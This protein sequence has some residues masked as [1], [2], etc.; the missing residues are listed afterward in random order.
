MVSVSAQPIAAD[1][2]APTVRESGGVLPDGTEYR[3][4]VPE[5]WNGT[6]IN[7]LDFVNN[8][9]NSLQELLLDRGYA[10]SGTKR[11][12]LRE[13]QYDPSQEIDNQV[14]V[15]DI[16][17][18]EYGEPD[19]ALQFGCSGGGAVAMGIGEAYPDKVDGVIAAGYQTGVVIGNMWLDLL[20]ILKGLLAPDSDLP[21]VGI[22]T[23]EE[24]PVLA[25]WREVLDSAQETKE[26][27]ARIALAVALAQWPT[28]GALGNPIPDK[29]DFND[30]DSVQRAM[31]RSIRDG[32]F[33][34]ITNRD[35]LENG[36]GGIASWNTDVDYERFYTNSEP[37][38][39]K[40]VREL[41]RNTELG[42]SDDLDQINQQPRVAGDR[43]AVDYWR[44]HP[45]THAGR[46]NVPVLHMHTLGDAGLPPSI[47]AGYAARVRSEGKT[48]L[49]RQA[50]VD[51]AGHCA[52]KVSEV[53]AAVET[54]LRRIDTGRWADTATPPRLNE[55]GR[56]FEVDEPRFIRH[57]LPELN[58]AFYPD[59]SYPGETN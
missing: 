36:A 21:V 31:Y 16:L 54:V 23:H 4:R 46:P 38:Q 48:S 30:P 52:F 37:A 5:N 6:V 43:D 22:A 25:A 20:F 3:I 41:Y 13:Q 50:F 17:E 56:S 29:P 7:D 24:G 12:P 47:M 40:L 35:V 26:G 18:N 19:H 33:A 53:A 42:L 59:S 49:Y 9:H 51:G 8:S 15:L 58:R 10:V 45:R 27:R 2:D 44:V 57:R 32:M 39:N 34:A 14:R 28:W 55:L 1:T 11:H